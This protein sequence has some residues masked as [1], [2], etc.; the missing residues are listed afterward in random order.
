MASFSLLQNFF[1]LQ[2]IYLLQNVFFFHFVDR[3]TL[4]KLTLSNICIEGDIIWYKES[5]VKNVTIQWCFILQ[6]SLRKDG[7]TPSLCGGH[8]GG[9][10][11]INVI[12]YT[13]SI[14]MY[15]IFGFI[16]CVWDLYL[17]FHKAND[18]EQYLEKD[19]LRLNSRS[20]GHIYGVHYITKHV[21]CSRLHWCLV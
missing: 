5:C 19:N 9:I 1:S 4:P 3:I 6:K 10:L 15:L 18:I 11:T 7:S 13:F 14:V 17:Y 21:F 8:R 20:H 12:L 16:F 2:A